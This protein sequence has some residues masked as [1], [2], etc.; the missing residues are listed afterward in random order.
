M[1]ET[2]SAAN[3]PGPGE[4]PNIKA[5][6]AREKKVA[7]SIERTLNFSYMVTTTKCYDEILMSYQI[8]DGHNDVLF[9]L[10]LKNKITFGF[11]P[12]I[13]NPIKNCL[14]ALVEI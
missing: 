4:I 13:K 7:K 11:V 3:V 2:E 14:R 1:V 9:R 12:P 8:F 10:F 5:A 6:P